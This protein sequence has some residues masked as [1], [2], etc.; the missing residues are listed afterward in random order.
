M[1]VMLLTRRLKPLLNK[2][3]EKQ[4]NEPMLTLYRTGG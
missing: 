4:N 3:S 1:K 2:E